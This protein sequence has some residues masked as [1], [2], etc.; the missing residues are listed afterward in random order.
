MFPNN[1]PVLFYPILKIE[2]RFC[3]SDLEYFRGKS[4][5][6]AQAHTAY[7]HR[8]DGLQAAGLRRETTTIR[9]WNP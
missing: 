1:T 7:K 2:L 6:L 3:L 9:Y 8:S 5:H 4:L